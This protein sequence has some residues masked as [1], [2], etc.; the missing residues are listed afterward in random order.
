VGILA[1]Q[2]F[3]I[4]QHNIEMVIVAVF[5]VEGCRMNL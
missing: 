5:I 2:K 3:A 1:L 4:F